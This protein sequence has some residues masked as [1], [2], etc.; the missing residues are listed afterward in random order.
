MHAQ[1]GT[2]WADND[3]KWA[4]IRQINVPA[5][6]G[7]NSFDLKA[8]SAI[9]LVSRNAGLPIPVSISASTGAQPV[10]RDPDDVDAFLIEELRRQWRDF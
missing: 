9:H 1:F 6:V 10:V 8:H 5:P 4:Q 3:D 7:L 2:N